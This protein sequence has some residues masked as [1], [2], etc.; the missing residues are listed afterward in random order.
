[1]R[2]RILVLVALVV[3]AVPVWADEEAVNAPHITVDAS[4]R[5]YAKSVP[6]ETYGSA[7]TTSVYRVESGADR[8]IESYPWYAPTLYLQC[9]TPGLSGD[10]VSIV[11]FGPWARGRQATAGHLA[12]AFHAKGRLLR[13]YSTLDI[14]GALDNVS[15]STSHYRVFGE[16]EGYVFES[17]TSRPFRLRTVDGRTLT[18]DSATGNLR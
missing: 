13:S 2:I 8:L 9:Y 14:A 17:S 5:C 16:V 1:M 6:A 3:L 12:I 15:A 10:A 7:G 18:F 11:Q 4:G